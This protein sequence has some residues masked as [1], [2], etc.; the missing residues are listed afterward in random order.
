MTWKTKSKLK[1]VSNFNEFFKREI[2]TKIS[3]AFQRKE[4]YAIL[5]Q[6]KKQGDFDAVSMMLK[7][8]SFV[9]L[10]LIEFWNYVI[11]LKSLRAF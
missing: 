10:F 9:F 3:A 2:P 4:K 11:R 7:F 5:F 6:V 1:R 8:I